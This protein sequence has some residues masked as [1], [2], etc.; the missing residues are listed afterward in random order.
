MLTSKGVQR[1]NLDHWMKTR[2]TDD[3]LKMEL[4]VFSDESLEQLEQKEIHA[5]HFVTMESCTK[6]NKGYIMMIRHMEQIDPH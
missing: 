1:L 2:L 6:N 3:V 4:Q 5:Y